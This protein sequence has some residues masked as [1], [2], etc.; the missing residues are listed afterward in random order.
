MSNQ[1]AHDD[2]DLLGEDAPW[3]QEFVSRLARAL[4]ERYR[5]ERA[6]AGDATARTWE[7]L[8]APFRASNLEH[9][10]HIRVKLAALGCRAVS[11]PAP[12]GE[13]FTLT[14]DEV[15]QLARME[16]DRWVDE[17][18]EGGWKDGPRDFHHRTTPSL[19]TW[20]QLSEEMREVDRLFVRAIPGVLAELG[21]RVER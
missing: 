19:V 20:D 16:H 8:P 14:D 11:G 4:H 12:D 17:R 6:A 3:D 2:S 1:P 10:E 15:T 9:A 7:E 5:R 13:Q 18:L 21:Y